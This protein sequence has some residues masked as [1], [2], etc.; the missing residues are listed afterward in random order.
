MDYGLV[1]CGCL[2]ALF[3]YHDLGQRVL[4]VVSLVEVNQAALQQRVSLACTQ[5]LFTSDTVHSFGEDLGRIG[6]LSVL[7]LK[8]L[9]CY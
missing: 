4:L 1:L 6:V 2:K 8:D 9:V 3:V 7:V 5:N